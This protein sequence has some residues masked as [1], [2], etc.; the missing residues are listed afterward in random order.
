MFRPYLERMRW[1]Q[2]SVRLEGWLDDAL[3]SPSPRPGSEA[4]L[5]QTSSS[6]SLQCLEFQIKV[7]TVARSIATFLREDLQ[8]P[9]LQGYPGAFL[10]VFWGALVFDVWTPYNKNCCSPSVL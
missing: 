6:S 1:L 7:R 4:L 5:P 3:S 10:P 9:A 2:A 8:T